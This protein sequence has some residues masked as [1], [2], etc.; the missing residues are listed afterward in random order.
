MSECCVLAGTG[1]EAEK[2]EAR[3]ISYPM[4][5]EGVEGEEGT[6]IIAREEIQPVITSVVA[7]FMMRHKLTL[8]RTPAAL[9]NGG[10]CSCLTKQ[11]YEGP[12]VQFC[13][14]G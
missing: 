1:K 3:T 4:R 10:W 6:L 7:D 5:E 8:W 13:S 2:L 14:V 11:N 9:V 12:Q